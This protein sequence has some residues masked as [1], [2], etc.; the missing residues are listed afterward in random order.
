MKGCSILLRPKELDKKKITRVTKQFVGGTSIE[1][2]P[3]IWK[4]SLEIH[5][6]LHPIPPFI[7]Q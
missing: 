4:D 3:F 1:M 2:R 6:H 7:Q 5:I